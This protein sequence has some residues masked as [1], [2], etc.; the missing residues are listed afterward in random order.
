MSELYRFGGG[1]IRGFMS[2]FFS[3]VGVSGEVLGGVLVAV[4]D[5]EVIAVDLD[6]SA[7][8]HITRSDIVHHPVHVLILSSFQ[9]SSWLY[10]R[11]LLRWLIDRDRV[12][13]KIERDDKSSINILW[14]LGV[15]PGGVSQD[16]FVVINILEEVNLRFLWHEI[17][18]ITERID[19]TSESVVG[20]NL[21]Y[22]SWSWQRLLNTAERE[23]LAVFKHE[24]VLSEFINASDFEYSS[25]SNERPV[26]FNFIAGQVPISDEL[27][28]WLIHL[29]AFG[30]SLSP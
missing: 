18:D 20:W 1:W 23:F 16:L 24:K 7:D 25:I 26:K 13:S 4:Q 27:L 21:D 2:L 6:V 22:H 14:H 12:V 29:E 9:E 15:E 8:W 17:I 11:V 19:F 3:L 28:T 10:T 5:V 30:K